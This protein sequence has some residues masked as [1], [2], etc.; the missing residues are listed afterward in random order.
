MKPWVS[1]TSK[2]VCNQLASWRTAVGS[3]RWPGGIRKTPIGVDLG[4]RQIKAVQFGRSAGVWQIQAVACLPRTSTEPNIS[5]EEVRRLRVL[6]SER[7]FRGNE[8]VVSVPPDRL[9]TGIMELPPRSSGAPIDQLAQ[10]ELSRMHKCEPGSIEAA[11]WP[12]PDPARA[13][14]TTFVMGVGCRHVDAN[15]LLDTLEQENTFRVERLE[16]QARAV[17]RA[18]EGLRRDV[19]GIAGILDVGWASA[20]LVLMFQDTVV[21]ERTL[22]RCGLGALAEPLAEKLSLKVADIETVLSGA[23]RLDGRT[24]KGK[25]VKAAAGQL[26]ATMVDEMRIP[27]SYLANQYPDAAMEQLCLVGGGASLAGLADHLAASLACE[28]RAV[29]PSDLARCPKSYDKDY[30]PMLAAAVGLGQLDGR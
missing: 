3:V 1:S 15:Q 14:N 27:L 19:S 9:L 25:G 21:Y 16:T 24:R 2:F 7:G 18:C 6:L 4:V 26:F 13:A 28:V 8:V 5:T 22:A 29:F 12:L 23:V 11:C 20:R 10:S 30:G 17:A